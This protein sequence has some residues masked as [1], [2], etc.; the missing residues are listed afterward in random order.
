MNF[1]EPLPENLVA[2]NGYNLGITKREYFAG[3]AMQSHASRV[4]VTAK[5][6]ADL[7]VKYADA[8][9]EELNKTDE[10]EL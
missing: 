8:L 3:L 2:Y 9:L 4:G 7:A 5:S 10:N 1:K 6:A